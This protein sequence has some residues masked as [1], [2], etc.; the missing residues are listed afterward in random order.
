MASIDTQPELDQTAN[1][2]RYRRHKPE[3]TSLYPII[4]QHLPRF[5]TLIQRFQSVKAPSRPGCP[6]GLRGINRCS[7][8]RLQRGFLVL[9]KLSNFKSGDRPKGRDENDEGTPLANA[10]RAGHQKGLVQI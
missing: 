3:E 4:E 5:L 9:V 8:T 2:V 7:E 1:L 10:P 6:S